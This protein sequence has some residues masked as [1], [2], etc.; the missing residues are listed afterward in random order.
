MKRKKSWVHTKFAGEWGK[1]L[2][3]YIHKKADPVPKN[4]LTAPQ[5]LLKMGLVGCSSGQRTTLL[6]RMVNDGA[7]IQKQFRVI[8][9]TGRRLSLINHYALAKK[10]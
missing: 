2:E 5:A 3:Q 8:D 1:A 6:Q 10:P 9:S 4:F 7:L